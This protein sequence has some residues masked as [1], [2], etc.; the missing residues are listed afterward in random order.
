M[1]SY[2]CICWSMKS[3]QC[4]MPSYVSLAQRL[5][6]RKSTSLIKVNFRDL[7]NCL[8]KNLLKGREKLYNT[9]KVEIL[10]LF[11][12]WESSH[13]NRCLRAFAMTWTAK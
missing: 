11:L 4:S 3:Y 1:Y 9:P 2:L 10:P 8:N 7:I 12:H 5:E 13:F 6:T